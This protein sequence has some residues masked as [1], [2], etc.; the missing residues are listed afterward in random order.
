MFRLF[1]N[2]GHHSLL[3]QYQLTWKEWTSV[4][5]GEGLAKSVYPK[6]NDWTLHEMTYSQDRLPLRKQCETLS[7]IVLFIAARVQ[8]LQPAARDAEL[9]KEAL[10]LGNSNTWTLVNRRWSLKTWKGHSSYQLKANTESLWVWL[11]RGLPT[12]AGMSSSALDMQSP[13]STHDELNMHSPAAILCS[14]GLRNHSQH[15]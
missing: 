11:R 7:Y 13:M 10:S 12:G 9:G 2:F 14:E 3:Q 5:C 4:S 1:F 15:S 8:I 6:H